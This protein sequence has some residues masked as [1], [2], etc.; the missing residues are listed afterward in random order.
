VKQRGVRLTGIYQKVGGAYHHGKEGGKYES[1]MRKAC[2]GGRGKKKVQFKRC[3]GTRKRKEKNS[4]GKV[5]D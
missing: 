5:D 2:K 3:S 4:G 1:N